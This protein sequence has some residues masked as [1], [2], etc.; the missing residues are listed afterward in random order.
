MRAV[1]LGTVAAVAAAVTYYALTSLA[2]RDIAA[3]L[4]LAGFVIGKAVRLGSG[5]RGGRRYQWLAAGLAYAMIASTYVPLVT[6]G[7]GTRAPKEAAAAPVVGEVPSAGAARAASPSPTIGAAALPASRPTPAHLVALLVLASAA[8][9]L[10]G[11]GNLASIAVTMLAVF[12]AW[13]MNRA[14]PAAIAGPFR[15]GGL[16]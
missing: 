16:G 1:A 2:G 12:I 13:R 7:F 11:F 10:A 8:P 9:V 3:V 14:L 5:G 6:S 15:A 4:V